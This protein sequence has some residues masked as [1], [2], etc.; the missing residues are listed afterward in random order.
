MLPE[1]NAELK[2][3]YDRLPN[4][5][6]PDD[7]ESRSLVELRELAV[8]CLQR[9]LDWICAIRHVVDQ[10]TPSGVTRAFGEVSRQ[11]ETS[12]MLAIGIS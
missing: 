7:P 11:K 10:L 4:R 9:A 5:L 3:G 6:D 12:K 1:G 2:H 8:G